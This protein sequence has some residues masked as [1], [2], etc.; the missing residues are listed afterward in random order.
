MALSVPKRLRKA[1]PPWTPFELATSGTP[2]SDEPTYLNSRYQVLVKEF[3]TGWT[4]L[5]IVRRD[6]S[7]IHDWRDLQRIKNELCHPEREAIE[8]YPAESRLVDTN[9]QYHLW[10]MPSGTSF[11]VGYASRDIAD[12]P[13]GRHKQRPFEVTPPDVNAVDHPPDAQTRFIMP[14]PVGRYDA[15]Q[16]DE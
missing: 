2:G 6:R 3:D 7:A 9:N 4:W 13:P 8:L 12:N 15:T 10:V 11:P 16:E 5:L 14:P 1:P